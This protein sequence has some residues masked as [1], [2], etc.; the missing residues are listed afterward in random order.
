M[1]VDYQTLLAYADGELEPDRVAEVE[2]KLADDPALAARLALHRRLAA[3]LHAAY[4]PVLQQPVPEG[5]R[6]GLSGV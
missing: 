6:R 2:R 1:T 5:L 4:D 3:R